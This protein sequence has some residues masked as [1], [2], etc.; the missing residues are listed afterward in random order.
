MIFN[1]LVSTLIIAQ[2]YQVLDR[3]RAITPF[4]RSPGLTA[5]MIGG[6]GMMGYGGYK[7]IQAHY[8]NMKN[9]QEARNFV[10]QGLIEKYSPSDDDSYLDYRIYLVPH[11]YIK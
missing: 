11:G 3:D 9:I 7:A 2:S 5:T 1:I 8:Q 10:L 6:L 4:L